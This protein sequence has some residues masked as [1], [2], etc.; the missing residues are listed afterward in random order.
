MAVSAARNEQLRRY[1]ENRHIDHIP[2]GARHGKPWHQFAFWFGG[3]VN[4]FNVVLGAVT[5]AIGLTF[6]WALIAIAAGTLI[7]ALLIALHATQ[8]PRLGVPQTIQS[9]G[10]FGFYGSA[11]M[12]PAVLLLNVG[13]IAAE[14]V[15]QAQAMNGVTAAL[16][17]PA[18]DRDPG[19]PLGGDRDL[20][21]P[22]DPPGH[23]G[24]RRRRRRVAGHHARPGPAVRR[25]ARPRDHL[26]RPD[27]RPVPGRGGAAGHRH[28]VV[29]PVRLRLHP[30][31]ARAD[32]RA[33]AVLGHLR[34]QRAG[35]LRLLRGRRLPGRAAARPRPGRGRRQDLRHR[36]RWSSWPSR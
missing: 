15:I 18:V 5:V 35:H 30:V 25:A 14:L 11:F 21:L 34:R 22:V 3:N 12:F 28:A 16:T 8:G 36:G 9:R 23:A 1:V 4:V 7:G 20:R 2:A 29:R 27:R 13:F 33:A 24:H 6:W 26:A 17:I 32:Q 19:R 10:Q 31:P